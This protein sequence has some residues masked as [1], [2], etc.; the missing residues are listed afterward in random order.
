VRARYRAL[1]AVLLATT[2]VLAPAVSA[3]AEPE[4]RIT[5]IASADGEVVAVLTADDLAPGIS[6]D[7]ASVSVT[8]NGDSVES[9]AEA[10]TGQESTV[11]QRAALAIDTSNSMRG[12]PLAAAK[13]AAAAFVAAVPDSVEIGLVT[14]DRAARE[15]IPP[16]TDRDS[17][18]QAVDELTT[19]AQTTVYE[20]LIEALD[21]VSGVP[22]RNVVL[23]SDGRDTA[24][25]ATFAD[26]RDVASTAGT[27]ID[28]V[29]LGRVG[30][31]RAEL[32]ELASL[33]GGVYATASDATD[34]ASRFTDA[35]E[36]I[37]NQVI[38]RSEYPSSLDGSGA[39]VVITATAGEVPL[40]AEAFTTLSPD[41]VSG[42]LSTEVAPAGPVAVA[43]PGWAVP[44]VGLWLGVASVAVGLFALMALGVLRATRNQDPEHRMLG[45][46]RTYSLNGS[47]PA[48]GRE[49]TA[50]GSSGAAVTA[51]HAARELLVR[52]DLEERLEQ[53]LDAAA[54]PLKPAEWLLAQGALA[55]GGG[56]LALVLTG[57]SWGWV[58]LTIATAAGV[59]WLVLLVK[60][61]G[62]KRAFYQQ[63]PDTLQLLASTLRAGYSLPQGIDT[64]AK[65]GEDPIA[66]EFR[67]AV[68][69]T[70]LGVT[71]EDALEAIAERMENED[72]A[73]VV[74][75]VRIQRQVGGNLSEVLTTVAAVLRER[76]YLRRQVKVL[77]AEGRLSAWIIGAIPIAFAGFLLVARPE[78]VSIMWTDPRGIALSVLWFI[79]LG[80]GAFWLSKVVKV[81][82]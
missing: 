40:R 71:P 37:A 6:I 45:R 32:E 72:F 13:D 1:T 2:G 80:S 48:R 28:I 67:R 5:S 78:M 8:L 49:Q 16:S 27:T 33:T 35:A 66:T 62:R 73:W 15:V 26:V 74:M 54:I 24:S 81:K 22:L 56:L 10:V 46:L 82:V 61:R 63:L 3:S 41:V 79:M 7:P 34:L 44:E 47:E 20:G 12:E 25:E 55:T 75:A 58:L 23:L 19:S 39:S 57:G 36:A 43:T 14:F 59:P 9:T 11:R 69:E 64:V 42:G 53:R 18:L 52:R 17:L 30:P 38:V 31:V 50:F 21:S 65:Q 60:E 77:S 68:I 4:A 51:V 29:G 76:E 70:R